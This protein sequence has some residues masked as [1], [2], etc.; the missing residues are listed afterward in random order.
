MIENLNPQ[1]IQDLEGARQAIILL[2]NLVE[3]LKQE[4]HALREEVQQLRDETIG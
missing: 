2:H 3:E 1:Q 4:N